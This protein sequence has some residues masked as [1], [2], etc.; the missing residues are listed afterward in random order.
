MG[1]KKEKLI[2]SY[3]SI[4]EDI[5]K[6]I[7]IL[8][9]VSFAE[10]Y[11][12]LDS[13]ENFDLSSRGWKYAADMWRFVALQAENKNSKPIV[14]LKGRQVGATT[15]AGGLS[16]YFTSSGLYGSEVNKPPMR[17]VHLF[18]TL[19]HVSK[20]TKDK[21]G[22]MMRNSRDNFIGARS[23]ENDPSVS[24]KIPEDSLSEKY[25]IGE[26]RLRIDSIGKDADRIRGTTQDVALF[27]ECQDMNRKAI[28]NAI[29]ILQHAKYGARA[30]GLQLFFG[31][32]KN[33]GSYFWSL[34][35]D[36]DQRFFQLK[37]LNCQD[38][39]FL[40]NLED[41]S[42]N[43]IW[44]S[45]LE[46]RCPHC[47]FHQDKR[48]AV[49]GGRWVPTRVNK[50]NKRV[51]DFSQNKK[52]IGFHH[53]LM[54]M[55][56]FTKED[57]LKFWHKFNQNVTERA[58]LNETLGNF[59][60]GGG[61]PL[62]LDDIINNALDETRGLSKS[63]SNNSG[64][65]VVLGMD[66][67]GKDDGDG[68]E[69]EN[70]ITK[71]QS[72]TTAIILSVDT[73]GVFTIENAFKLKK[74]DIMYHVNVVDNIF[75]KYQVHT[76]VADQAYGHQTVRFLQVDKNYRN[77]FLG[78]LNNGSLGKLVTYDPKYLRITVNKDMMID[79]IFDMIRRGRIKFPALGT[80][81]EQ[82]RWLADHCTSME[83]ATIIKNGNAVK[84]Y[85]KGSGPN[86]GLMALMYA[87]LA[88]KYLSTGAFKLSLNENQQ[89]S[90][91]PLP[92]M[93]YIPRIR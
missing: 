24:G 80:A 14:E 82:L 59:Y 47:A 65:T 89:S 70:A 4:F 12:T 22:P 33:T 58:W 50:D 13:G 86:D 37:C 55:P 16:L 43:D 54:L 61:Q 27:D 8:D 76:A 87:V 36:S 71:G 30:E 1:K 81:W 44:V 63:I 6:S 85:K 40:Y 88:Y 38:Y 41:D 51:I 9:P 74:N 60:R 78:C 90:G 32:P 53:N 92:T 25:F 72:Y 5:K 21:L 15:K 69:E 35:N 93:A 2:S 28:E 49:D 52:Y 66:W 84:T 10:H 75:N 57:V 46:I 91:M 18:P 73:S 3:N 79:E 45:G 48:D 20:Y 19:G 42:W 11:L 67:G 56:F 83:S 64:K 68:G 77:R 62:T 29:K 39:F 31:T 34:W 23:L 26:N 7:S 17:V